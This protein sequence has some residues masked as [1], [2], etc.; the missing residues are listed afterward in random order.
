ML[1]IVAFAAGFAASSLSLR[2]PPERE[3]IVDAQAWSRTAPP[4][5]VSYSPPSEPHARC[6][7]WQITDV[8][9]EEVLEEML[10]RGWRAPSQGDAI[11][12]ANPSTLGDLAAINPDA[13]MP[14]Q[15]IWR[16]SPVPDT[17][18]E[19]PPVVEIRPEAPRLEDPASPVEGAASAPPPT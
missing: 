2:A 12:F 16:L 14:A 19:D 15:S 6:S 18:I 1:V 4:P 13:P 9:M 5:L 7:P 17:R 10:R 3:P 11:A 8:A